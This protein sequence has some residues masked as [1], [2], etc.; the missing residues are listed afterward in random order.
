MDRRY[1]TMTT[2]EE[3]FLP[4]ALAFGATTWVEEVEFAAALRR[5][6]EALHGLPEISPETTILAVN[7]LVGGNPHIPKPTK[8]DRFIDYYA[9]VNVVGTSIVTPAKWSSTSDIDTFLGESLRRAEALAARGLARRNISWPGREAV[10]TAIEVLIQ[11][12]A[13]D[14]SGV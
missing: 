13:D 3:R 8:V 9:D 10:R 7:Y 4:V 12:V 14:Q 11:Q 2:R 1:T 5:W 6:Q